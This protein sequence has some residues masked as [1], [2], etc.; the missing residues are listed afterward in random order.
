MNLA[1][2]FLDVAL[3][4]FVLISAIYATYR[5]F[6]AESLSVFAWVAAAFATLYFGP[7]TSY[8][9]R[10]MVSPPWLGEV[11]GYAVV[12][13]V[14]VL[15]L[16]FAS[17][18]FAASVK[19]SQVGTLDA[20]LGAGFG[21]LRGLV[22]VGIAYLVL[23]AFQ[24]LSEQPRWI[25]DARLMPVVLKSAE[26]VSSLIPDQ[27][28]PGHRHEAVEKAAETPP[29]ASKT[30]KSAHAAAAVAVHKAAAKKH[31]KK[32]YGAKDRQALDKLIETSSD[33][34]SGKP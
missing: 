25:T 18:R 11:V 10:G 23:T 19:K 29:P 5:G 9:M 22:V 7:W 3:V 30:V 2:Q 27:N 21:V 8:W 33:T 16:S 4:A 15:P 28:I 32:T 24:P 31:A 14:V 13:I 12:F 20:A 26:V 1:F 17:S 6:V 34:K